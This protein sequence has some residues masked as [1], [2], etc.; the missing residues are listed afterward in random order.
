MNDIYGTKKGDIRVTDSF[1]IYGTLLGNATVTEGGKLTLYGIVK[2]DV[3][4][5]RGGWLE[6]WG[7]VEGD[8]YD[9]GGD[10]TNNGHIGGRWHDVPNAAR[11][12]TAITE[13]TITEP[14]NSVADASIAERAAIL[15][16]LA[17]QRLSA[18]EANALLEAL[19]QPS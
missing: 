4:V 18:E 12:E 13:G 5:E 7:V 17:E 8:L 14:A 6:Q 3:I 19:D 9:R 1:G 10:I 11:S 2:G 15:R 16:M